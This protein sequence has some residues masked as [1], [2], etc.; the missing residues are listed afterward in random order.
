MHRR[1]IHTLTLTVLGLGL[2]TA[3]RA[4]EQPRVTVMPV[5]YFRADAPSAANLTDSLWKEFDGRDYEMVSQQDAAAKFRGMGLSPKRHYP[6]AA[7]I[8]FGRELGADVVAYPRLLA[9]GRQ[10][11]SKGALRPA[12]VVL[13][14]V[15]NVHTGKAI[16]ARQIAQEFTPNTSVRLAKAMEPV[17]RERASDAA[18]AK[19]SRL[20]FSRV[21]GSREELTS[22]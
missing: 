18:A 8:R 15:V 20:Y 14:R 1:A 4:E 16:Y 17:L 13:L 22:P 12:A 6:D 7:A 11:V 10:K 3:V 2:A 5:Q 9:L 19:V 21:A